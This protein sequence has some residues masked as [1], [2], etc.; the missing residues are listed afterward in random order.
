MVNAADETSARRSGRSAGERRRRWPWVLGGVLGVFVAGAVVVGVLGTVLAREA[1][2]VRDDLVAAR[3]SIETLGDA[4]KAKDAAAIQTSADELTARTSGAADIVAGPLWDLA[5]AVPQVG[6]NIDAVQRVTLSAKTLVDGALDPGLQIMSAINVE[7][8]ALEGGG[9]DLEPFRGAAGSLPAIADAFAAAKAQTDPIDVDALLPAVAEPVSQVR[10][11]IDQT[12]PTLDVVNRYLPT[13]LGMAGADGPRTYLL[14]FQNNAEIRATGGNPAASIIMTVDDGRFA[15]ADQTSSAT[16]K[17]TGTAGVTFTTLP[18][19]TLSLYPE[20]LTRY[21]QDYSMTPDFPT[22]AQLFQDLFN[23]SYGDRFDGV[24]SIDPVVLSN[25]LAV[26]GPVTVDGEEIN[27][28]NAVRLLLSDAYERYPRGTDSDVFFAAV[29]QAVF[30][31]LTA[32]KWDP[33]KMLDALTESARQQRVYLAFTDPTAQALAVELNVDGALPEDTA[34]TTQ[35]GIY[36]NDWGVGKIEYHLAT[37]MDARCD[38]DA[39]TMS[40]S[41]TMTNSIP[42]SIQSRYTLTAK[43]GWYG[44]PN[45][46]MLIDTLFFAPPGATIVSVDPGDGD[47]PGLDRAGTEKGSTAVSKLVAL[48]QDE[49]RTVSYTVQF[50]AGELGPLDLRHTP[51]ASATPVNIDASCAAMFPSS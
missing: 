6:A 21:S 50:P 25:M 30:E 9:I 36:L 22:T 37:V 38:A 42:D 29:S 13:L 40:V 41:Q 23:A 24:I 10:A 27:A 14:V 16:F 32:G 44:L 34:K 3:A 33:A 35:L 19:E 17:A 1:F 15:L 26:A 7:N 47:V 43:A 51:T 11:V 39:R 4:V 2:E 12:A 31:H 8:L 48:A 28:D 5:A 49:T 20:T 18:P 46:T 45:T